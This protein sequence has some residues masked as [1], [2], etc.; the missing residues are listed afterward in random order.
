METNS[1]I[2][3]ETTKESGAKG[4]IIYAVVFIGLFALIYGIIEY[5]K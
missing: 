5:M 4:C 3:N 2:N 1:E